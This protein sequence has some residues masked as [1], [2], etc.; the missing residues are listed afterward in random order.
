MCPYERGLGSDPSFQDETEEMREVKLFSRW[1]CCNGKCVWGPWSQASLSLPITE[2]VDERVDAEGYHKW[3]EVCKIWKCL[4]T[5]RNEEE[6]QNRKTS[7][8]NLHWRQKEWE[9]P[10][11]GTEILIQWQPWRPNNFQALWG[12][13]HG[14][15]FH[16]LSAPDLWGGALDTVTDSDPSK[17]RGRGKCQ[18]SNFQGYPHVLL[19]AHLFTTTHFL[20]SS[21]VFSLHKSCMDI[22][23]KKKIN[24]FK[25]EKQS[26]VI[27][28]LTNKGWPLLIR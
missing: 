4:L 26:L 6:R 15:P 21:K 16:L 12:V 11:P 7:E 19:D 27:S 18:N 10:T 24:R 3:G 14:P 13:L 28:N 25:K 17:D 20:L 2:N 8:I 5:R 9:W 1:P 22:W 23:G